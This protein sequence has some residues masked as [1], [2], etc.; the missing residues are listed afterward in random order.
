M[1]MNEQLVPVFRRNYGGRY[2]IDLLPA[3]GLGLRRD[4]QASAH[5]ADGLEC[6]LGPLIGGRSPFLARL[7]QNIPGGVARRR[8]YPLHLGADICWHRQSPRRHLQLC[9]GFVAEVDGNISQGE[10]CA[11]ERKEPVEDHGCL[12]SCWLDYSTV[13]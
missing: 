11:G 7:S 6:S 3:P 10:S 5:C 8:N 2:D 9:K 12:L 13:A 1:N 4:M